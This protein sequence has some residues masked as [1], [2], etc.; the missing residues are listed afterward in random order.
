MKKKDSKKL[1]IRNST[2]E[3]LIFTK[4]EGKNQIEVRYEK[5][6]IWLTQ[7]L[8]AELFSVERSVITKHLQNIFNEKELNKDSVCANF[9]HTASDGKKYSTLFY[10]LDAIISVG[11]RV[12]SKRATQFRQWATHVLR[13][14]A[15]K[16]YILDKK[17]LENGS[18]LGEDYFEHLLSE[19][20]EIRLSERRF[21]QK[22]TDI[23]ATSIDYNKE[24]PTTR[25][26]FAKAQNKLH[27][28]VHSQTAAELIK[29]RADSNKKNMGLTSWEN[30]P[31]GKILKTDVSVA[32]NYLTSEELESLGRV[33]SAYL[34]LAEDRAKRK[35]PMT[36]E[37]WAKRLDQFLKF[38]E[39]EILDNAGTISN[40]IAK[41]FAESEFEKYRIVQDRLFESDFDK[42]AKKLEQHLKQ[43]KET[44]DE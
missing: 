15:I 27:Y 33:V 41:D 34:D 13:E 38:D 19:I 12:N 16:G 31:K 42:E 36:M 44:K 1:I 40:A 28:A 3:F 23:Y 22:I 14:F 11:Y 2:A 18:F 4:Q 30:S 25:D 5:G 43:K 6:T 32:K 10:N 7:K 20:R 24:A 35:I 26:F 9:A 21:Y 37:D 39:R 17:R 29:Q 8:I